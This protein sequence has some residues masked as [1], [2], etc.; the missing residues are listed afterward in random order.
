MW[1]YLGNRPAHSNLPIK[2]EDRAKGPHF[3]TVYRAV[4]AGLELSVNQETTLKGK[5]HFRIPEPFAGQAG[6]LR[7]TLLPAQV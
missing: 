6:T 5:K 7:L 2:F 4:T 1:E 3:S